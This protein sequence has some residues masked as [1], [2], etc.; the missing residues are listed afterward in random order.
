MDKVNF[1]VICAYVYFKWS[2]SHD[3]PVP[4]SISRYAVYPLTLLPFA[5]TTY[6]CCC[7]FLNLF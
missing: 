1:N 2:T 7:I 4:V 3:V 5:Y 6:I